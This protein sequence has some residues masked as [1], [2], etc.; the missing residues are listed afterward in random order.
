MATEILEPITLDQVNKLAQAELDR[1]FTDKG[2]T[3]VELTFYRPIFY[4]DNVWYGNGQRFD[5]WRA[6][7]DSA[8]ARYTVWTVPTDYGVALA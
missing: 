2:L 6:A 1:H 4:V 5:S 8:K 3:H 7:H